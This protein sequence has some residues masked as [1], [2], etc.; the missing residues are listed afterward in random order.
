MRIVAVNKS[1]LLENMSLAK[2]ALLALAQSWALNFLS[3]EA[4][5]KTFLTFEMKRKITF[6]SL[7]YLIL[8]QGNETTGKYVR[9]NP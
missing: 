2:F 8:K 7:S 6:F 9:S 3:Q 1:G 4:D 5:L